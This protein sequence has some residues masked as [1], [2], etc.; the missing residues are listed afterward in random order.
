L[1]ANACKKVETKNLDL[2]VANDITEKDSGFGTDTNRVTLIG[3]EGSP[4]NLPLLS[5]R[6]VA[7]RI[8]DRVVRLFK[9]KRKHHA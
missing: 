7:D 8:L 3:K 9:E 2:I 1:L 6:E 5:K 4:E